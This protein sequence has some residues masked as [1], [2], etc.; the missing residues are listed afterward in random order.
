MVRN[1]NDHDDDMDDGCEGDRQDGARFKHERATLVNRDGWIS[2]KAIARFSRSFMR[3]EGHEA[4]FSPLAHTNTTTIYIL[5]WAHES[6]C[7]DFEKG[8]DHHEAITHDCSNSGLQMQCPIARS[9]SKIQ[10][11]KVVLSR[12]KS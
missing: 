3:F 2:L 5:A 8:A 1:K 9:L 11:S 10:P 6:S 12:R 4:C 7:R